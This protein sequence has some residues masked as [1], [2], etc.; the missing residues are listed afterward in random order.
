MRGATL[1]AAILALQIFLP[2]LLKRNAG[3]A[4]LLRTVMDKP[5]FADIQI[6]AARPTMPVICLSF[7]QIFLELVI[8][9]EGAERLLVCM[10]A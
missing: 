10:I 4:S 6:P 5:V 2:I 9:R 8:I 7:N 3:P 1:H